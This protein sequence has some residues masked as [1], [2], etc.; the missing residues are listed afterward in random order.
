MAGLAAVVLASFGAAVA[1]E[2][3]LPSF[4]EVQAVRGE[5]AYSAS[6]AGCHGNG[7][8]DSFPAYPSA[9]VFFEFMSQNMPID[10]PGSLSPAIYVDIVA[11]LMSKAGFVPGAAEL[12][13]DRAILDQINPSDPAQ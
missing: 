11:F 13:A 2:T 1:Q 3:V 12:P 10:A 6:C 7:I 8:E 9:G 5:R 4:T